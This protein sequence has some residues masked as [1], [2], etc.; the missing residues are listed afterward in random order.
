[1]LLTF[2]APDSTVLRVRQVSES[3]GCV[4]RD[5]QARVAEGAKFIGPVWVGSGRTVPAGATVVGPAVIWDDPD[6]RPVNDVI[7]WLQIE[8]KEQILFWVICR[9]GGQ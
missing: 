9:P 6:R 5:A 4:W 1:M 8:P 7:Q 2:D 3:G